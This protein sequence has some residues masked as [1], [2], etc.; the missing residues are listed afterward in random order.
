MTTRQHAGAPRPVPR[1]DHVMVRVEPAG[2]QEVLRSEFMAQRFARLREKRASSSLAGQYSTLGVAGTST[3]IELFHAD[4]P[5]AHGPRSVP[6]TGGLVFSFEEPGSSAAARALMDASG[7]GYHHDLVTRTPDGTDTPQP[8]YQLVSVDLGSASPL[9]LLLNEVT[10][11]YLRAL[12]ARP[13][14]DG[15]VRRRDYLDAALGPRDGLPRL[16]SDIAGVTLT[17][18]PDRMNRIAQVLTLFGYTQAERGDELEL[19]GPGLSVR[20]RADNSAAERIC[21]VRVALAAEPDAP[22]APSAP[23]APA[24]YRFGHD[25]TLTVRAGGP[26]GPGGTARWTFAGTLARNGLTRNGWS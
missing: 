25:S 12:G 1:I 7:V 13:A 15:T 11:A 6:L 10:P 3:L 9:V 14:P 18:R 5:S 21:E 2:Y 16:M 4:L 26:G 24:E 22:G 8:W 17:V 20:L 23:S 19:R